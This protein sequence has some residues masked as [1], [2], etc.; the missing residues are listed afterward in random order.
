MHAYMHGCIQA[1]AKSTFILLLATNAKFSLIKPTICFVFKTWLGVNIVQQLSS[2]SELECD[3]RD[4]NLMTM[5][6][7]VEGKVYTTVI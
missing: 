2:F 3:I 4:I 1:A 6:E 5:C 7:H